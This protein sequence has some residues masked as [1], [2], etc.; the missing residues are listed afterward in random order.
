LTVRGTELIVL[1]LLPQ[2]VS[3][4][5]KMTMEYETRQRRQPHE[6]EVANERMRASV[7]NHPKVRAQHGPRLRVFSQTV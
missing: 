1:P 2:A 6:G 7:A 4:S 5:A 3:A